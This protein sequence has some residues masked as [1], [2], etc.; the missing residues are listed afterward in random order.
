MRGQRDIAS[1]V[2]RFTQELWE[3]TQGDPRIEWR[4]NIRHVQSG[5][6][7]HFTDFTEAMSFIQQALMKLTLDSVQAGAPQKASAARSVAQQVEQASSTPTGEAAGE[8]DAPGDSPETYQQKALRESFKLWEKF[9]SGYAD[10]MMGAVQRAAE[11]SIQ[12]TEVI[13]KQ[14]DRTMEQASTPLLR[15]WWLMPPF[16]PSAESVPTTPQR[17]SSTEEPA[18]STAAESTAV[19]QQ[20]ILD[21]LVALQQQMSALSNKIDQMEDE[22]KKQDPD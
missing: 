19:D 22:L 7:H 9:A 8:A 5:D 17:A 15:P 6:E 4:G 11:Q 21:T 20:A 18:E 13:K 10:L 1:F 16:V 14:V 3:D 12:Q 2:L